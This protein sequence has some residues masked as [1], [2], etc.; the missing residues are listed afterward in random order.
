MPRTL[1]ES[2]GNLFFKLFLPMLDYVN[3]RFR[4]VPGLHDITGAKS[5]E[6]LKVK[7]IADRIWQDTA[8]IDEY[9]ANRELPV[10]HK[11]I[12]L[13]W[14][15]KINSKFAVDRHLSNGSIFIDL[16]DCKVYQVCGIKSDWEEMFG[17]FPLPIVIDAVL[18]PFRDV[19]ITDGLI[20]PYLDFT[21]GPDYRKDLK[22][23][24]REAK[25]SGQVIKALGPA[26]GPEKPF[27]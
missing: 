20:H 12:L 23:L 21:I 16:K 19:I 17:D 25:E 6:I 10:D 27:L 22:I 15:N 1:S 14:K 8:L 9:T 18:I 7:K 13:S 3:D 4:V 2:D 26:H 24:Y 5:L 11:R